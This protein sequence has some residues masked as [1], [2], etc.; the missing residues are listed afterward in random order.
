MGTSSSL[1]VFMLNSGVLGEMTSVQFKECAEGLFP[2]RYPELEVCR[3]SPGTM[4]E[5]S[6]NWPRCCMTL[7]N[8]KV[9]QKQYMIMN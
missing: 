6:S 9:L 8:D 4:S 7:I 2:I 1:S 3:Y 5:M